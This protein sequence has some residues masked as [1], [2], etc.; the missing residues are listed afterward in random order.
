MTITMT[1][2]LTMT[3][4]MMI[5]TII[6]IIFTI[7]H[8]DVKCQRWTLSFRVERM[9]SFL[10]ERSKERILNWGSWKYNNPKIYL[11]FGFS[12]AESEGE[13]YSRSFQ[14]LLL[15]HLRAPQWPAPVCD[16]LPFFLLF[17]Q[18]PQYYPLHF[19]LRKWKWKC[20]GSDHQRSRRHQVDGR[21]L[22]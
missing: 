12:A 10:R 2:T 6:I 16:I 17:Y 13:H 3:M 15:H 20:C 9:E 5:M 4:M 19:Q 21:L 8:V 7:N 11:G 18:H 1:M 14:Y 22:H